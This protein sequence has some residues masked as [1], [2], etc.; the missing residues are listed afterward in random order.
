MVSINE[1]RPMLTVKDVARLLNIH[2][3][4]VRRWS[5]LNIIK[6]YRVTSRGDRRF[7]QEDI[8]HY[9]T[10]LNNESGNE[11]IGIITTVPEA[12]LN[13]QDELENV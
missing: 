10:E 12:R 9:L 6:S 11:S 8:A 13:D 3:N 5:D 2:V 4:T 1:M 7:R